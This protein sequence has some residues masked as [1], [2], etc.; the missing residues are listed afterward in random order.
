MENKHV[1]AIIVGISVIVGVIVW[2]FNEGLKKIVGDTCT[3]GP[4]C[5]MFDTIAVQ[6]W[7]SLAIAGVIFIIGLSIIFIKP[8]T[9]IIL[10]KE[11]KKK[12]DL[13]GL[14]KQEKEAADLIIKEGGVFQKT[15]M[16]KLNIG[17]VGMTRLLDKLESKGIIERKRRGMNN[18]VAL[19]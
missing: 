14:N 18:F 2:I 13:S 12:L 7:I 9:K 4:T 19:R 5:S 8:K 17:K 11:K 3:H 6:T 10:K 16:E 1:G 15:L